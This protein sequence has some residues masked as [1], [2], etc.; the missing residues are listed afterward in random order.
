[1]TASN[2]ARL[3]LSQPVVPLTWY[4]ASSGRRMDLFAIT[5]SITDSKGHVVLA[6]Q[7]HDEASSSRVEMRFPLGRKPE[8]DF[9]S[10]EEQIIRDGHA[11][12]AAALV[13]LDRG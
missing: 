2:L 5:I 12:L 3:G 4:T 10:R 13:A 11:I 8:A 1:M 9:A 6:D 7:A